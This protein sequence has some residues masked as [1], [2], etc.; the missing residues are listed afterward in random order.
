MVRP[1]C[2]GKISVTLF[3]ITLMAFGEILPVAAPEALVDIL[4]QRHRMVT[5]FLQKP[6]QEPLRMAFGLLPPLRG[7]IPEPDFLWVMWKLSGSSAS[8]RAALRLTTRSTQRI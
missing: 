1:V 5:E 6:I 4:I 7:L 2:S 8:H 3:Q